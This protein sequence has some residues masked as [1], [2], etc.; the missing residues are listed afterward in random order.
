MARG[1]NRAQLIGRLGK[2]PEMRYTKQ[3]TAVTSFSVATGGKWTDRDGNERDDTEW[4]RVVAWNKLAEICNQYL[5]KGK[6][7]YIEGRLQ[8]R[9]WQDQ[10]GNDRYTTEIIANDMLMLGNKDDG[11]SSGGGRDA[12][13][14]MSDEDIPF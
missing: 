12:P 6:Q 3:G 2:D 10:S 8:T 1:L 9:K 5:S 7:V 14:E 11:G 13:P 4:H